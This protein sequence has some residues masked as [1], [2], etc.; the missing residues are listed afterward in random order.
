M[1]V[2]GES[3]YPS[4]TVNGGTFTSEYRYAM[5]VGNKADGGEG[6][7]AMVTVNNGTFTHGSGVESCINVVL[8]SDNNYGIG[9]LKI[10][11]G[12]YSTD[13]SEINGVETC[14]YNSATS[15]YEVNK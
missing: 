2:A 8:T 3:G 7:L 9:S 5:H 10:N 13:V 12:N 6:N 14:V 4:V 15:Y 1:Y 11:G